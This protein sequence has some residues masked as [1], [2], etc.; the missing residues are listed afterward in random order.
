MQHSRPRGCDRGP[1][2]R[3]GRLSGSRARPRARART[4][5]RPWAE[6]IGRLGPDQRSEREP[7]RRLR[8]RGGRHALAGGHV[9]DRRER[10][11][12]G[13]RYRVGPN[14]LAGLARVRLGPLGP[15]RRQRGQRHR[16]DVQ[17]PRRSP[18]GP[19][20]RLVRRSV[21]GEHRRA[22]PARLRAQRGRPG[23]RAGLP[24]SRP[25]PAADLRLG[26]V[27]G[28]RERESAELPDALPARSASPERTEAARDDESQRQQHRRLPRPAETERCRRRRSSTTRPRRFR[29]HSR[30]RHRAGSPQA[31]PGRAR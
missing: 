9:R 18:T 30:S 13:S 3:P 23:D 14:R 29:S 25:S 28:A 26:E 16:D 15:D 10:W 24:D 1:R 2:R 21:P 5:K 11:R 31:R 7:H 27:A 17:G 20:G 22:R 8:P 4:R 19:Q 12:R 6:R